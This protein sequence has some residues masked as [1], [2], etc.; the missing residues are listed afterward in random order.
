MS[1]D[2]EGYEA[3]KELQSASRL[4]DPLF[5]KEIEQ[6][7]EVRVFIDNALLRTFSLLDTP[8]F[9][10]DEQMDERSLQAL[11]KTDLVLWVTDATAAAKKTEF[12]KL[13]IIKRHVPN[14]HLVL[15][16]GDINVV[17]DEAH[18][19][20]LAELME[21]FDTNNFIDY[22]SN[23]DNVHLISCKIW[24][25]EIRR[26]EISSVSVKQKITKF[27]AKLCPCFKY[28][29]V[30]KST[31]I[32]KPVE[33]LW[34]GYFM[35]YEAGLKNAVLNNDQAISLKLINDQWKRLGG[36][37]SNEI[38]VYLELSRMLSEF[39]GNNQTSKTFEQQKHCLLSNL[40]NNLDS[41]L[42][43][44]FAHCKVSHD[45]FIKKILTSNALVMEVKKW[46]LYQSFM[47][48]TKSY[49]DF[50]TDVDSKNAT[51]CRAYLQDVLVK[52]PSS[53]VNL[54]DS[55]YRLIGYGLLKE[56][57]I[58]YKLDGHLPA[59]GHTLDLLDQ[60]GLSLWN[61]TRFNVDWPQS[62]HDETCNK[63]DSNMSFRE[64]AK[65]KLEEALLSDLHNDINLIIN[66]Q[67]LT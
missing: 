38:S 24:A 25:K 7:Q 23:K 32:T 61:G 29:P 50:I 49:N 54:R 8:G 51:S 55:L 64:Y 21:Y 3:F 5:I 40:S 12:E 62:I 13:S 56:A 17:D 45:L 15:N 39:D 34:D 47:D 48:L 2:Q 58:S 36:Q 42:A 18:R 37:I 1:K 67:P 65:I 52:I 10:H 66:D 43:N 46:P 27:A 28:E 4:N 22:F 53:H 59:V 20:K 19:Q 11:N 9:N 6:I 33:I 60:M 35:Q 41:V 31:K 44:L 30:F 63:I 14:I 16:K 26:E 57:E